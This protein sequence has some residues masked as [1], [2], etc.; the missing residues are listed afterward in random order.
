MIPFATWCGCWTCHTCQKE[1]S[2]LLGSIGFGDAG[3]F[4]LFAILA[5]V[6]P[7]NPT[8]GKPSRS[9]LLSNCYQI[10]RKLFEDAFCVVIVGVFFADYAASVHGEGGKKP[11]LLSPTFVR[12]T[13]G[14]RP[15]TAIVSSQN[16]ENY[17]TASSEITMVKAS[18]NQP[19]RKNKQQ[20]VQFPN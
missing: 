16:T 1:P 8:Q 15:A 6:R 20:P 3:S 12:Y 10:G 13:P 14:Y 18:E 2:P 17:A 5:T 4:D 11:F 9:R 19:S 7:I